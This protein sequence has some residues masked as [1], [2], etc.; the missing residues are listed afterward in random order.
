M[1]EE[2]IRRIVNEAVQAAAAQIATAALAG[3]NNG[4][5]ST[6]P[7]GGVPGGAPGGLPDNQAM[8]HRAKRPPQFRPRDVGYFNLD[9]DVP[10]IEAKETHNIY[11]NMF[12]LTNR[13]RVKVL[14]INAALLRQNIESYLLRSADD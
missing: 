7:P 11:H 12:S 9:P 4:N 14:I 2:A 3:A 13:L 1:D 6:T 10:P 8:A 5:D